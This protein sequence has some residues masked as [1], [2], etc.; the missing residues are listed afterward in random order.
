MNRIKELRSAGSVKQSDLAAA[1]QV[2]QAALSGYETEKFQAD[3]DTYKKIAAYFD[4]SLDYLLGASQTPKTNAAHF[5]VPV[6]GDVAA[7]I[8]IEAITDILDYEEID[9]ALARTGEF[10]G[11]RIKGASMEP[12]MREGDV[13][14]VRQIGR[15]H[16]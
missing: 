4:V 15:A 9:A 16:V 11:L 5:K 12:R 2:S 1:I 10:F 6:L 14:I 7:G 3:I 13:V 8:P